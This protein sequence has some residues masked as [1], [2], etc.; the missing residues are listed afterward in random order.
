MIN[1]A[2]LFS[3][4]LATY[5]AFLCLALS[6]KRHW[7]TVSGGRGRPVVALRSAGVGLLLSSCLIAIVRDGAD[8]GALLWVT[9]LSIAALGVAL[10]LTTLNARLQNS[11]RAADQSQEPNHA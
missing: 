7:E 9:T 5:L 11:Q 3:L 8:Y 4:F 6:Q 1:A 10:T 2:T